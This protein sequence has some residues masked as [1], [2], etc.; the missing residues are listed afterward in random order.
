ML[1]TEQQELVAE[2][3]NLIYG[4]LRKRN[5]PAEEWY[6]ACAI[7]LCQAAQWY[8]PESGKK[9]STLAYTI[10]WH[11]ICREIQARKYL[12][13]DHTPLSLDQEF[14]WDERE[15]D[16]LHT[17]VPDTSETAFETIEAR[18]CLESVI[19]HFPLREQKIINDLLNGLSHREIGNILGISRERVSQLVRRIRINLA[20]YIRAE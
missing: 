13:R 2:N 1:T 12:K 19:R 7:G 15:P 16:T 20:D 11:E 10:M 6:D 4:L 8:N 17:I 9:F 5:L 14:T 18:I 3:H